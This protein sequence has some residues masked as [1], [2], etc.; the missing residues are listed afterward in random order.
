MP[1]LRQLAAGEIADQPMR[2]PVVGHRVLGRGAVSDF[3]D[4]Q[5]GTPSGQTMARQYLLHPGAVGIIAWDDADRIAVVRQYRHPVG[6]RLTEPPAGLLDHADE[7]FVVAAAR[8]LAEE[9]GIRAAHWQVLVD[10]FTTPGANQESL[11]IFLARGLS[12][13]PAPDGFVA[14]HEEAD[15]E[16]CW[17]ARADLVDAVFAGR[18]QNPT[19]VAGVLALETARLAGRLDG[20]RPGAAPWPA[21]EVWQAHNDQLAAIGDGDRS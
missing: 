19:M 11:R 15:M 18:L 6:F 3:V 1:E 2:W 5:V 14:D 16:V 8:E 17:A 20:L 7:D 12:P 10:T 13:A 21:R 9:A 4:D